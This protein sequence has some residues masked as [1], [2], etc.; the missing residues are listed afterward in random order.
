MKYS[1]AHDGSDPAHDGHTRGRFE[2]IAEAN[3]LA[4]A[5]GVDLSRFIGVIAVVNAN[6]D[7]SSDGQGNTALAVGQWF[8]QA[9]WK[10]S[11]VDLPTISCPCPGGGNHDHTGSGAYRVGFSSLGFPG[12]DKW[13]YCHICKALSY[14]GN[15]TVG[16]CAGGGTHDYTGSG[17][18]KLCGAND[19]FNT[20]FV[21]HETGHCLGLSH[22]WS[23][24]PDAEYGDPYDIMS[25]MR[26]ADFANKFPPGRE[27]GPGLNAPT[28]DKLGWLDESRVVSINAGAPAASLSLTAL[29]HPENSGTLMARVTSPNH[30]YT[31]EL[32]Q[33]SGWD[34]GIGQSV[35]LIHELR[36]CYTTGQKD[37]RWCRKCQ[38]LAWNGQ[39]QCPAGALHNYA[40]SMNYN[41]VGNT[42]SFAGQNNWKW[43]HKCSLLSY[44]AN[45]EGPGPC[46][47]GG[48]HDQTNSKNYT[49]LINNPSAPGQHGWRWC[50]KCQGLAY[51]KNSSLGT[52]AAGGLHEHSGSADYA[53]DSHPPGDSQW[54]WCNKC[55]GLAA[56]GYSSCV[57]D[58]LAH[59]LTQSSPYAV[60][61][62]DASFPGD[63][64]FRF[65]W[66]CTGLANSALGAK[67]CK[68]DWGI[69]DFS[70]SGVVRLLRTP[71]SP[72]SL[73]TGQSQWKWCR[74]CALVSFTGSGAAPCQAGGSHDYTG[75]PDYTLANFNDDTTFSSVEGSWPGR[76]TATR[77]GM[78]RF[79]LMRSTARLGRRQ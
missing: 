45:P 49:L 42:P 71:A 50:T 66:K 14:A 63:A 38:A 62:D 41:V 43:C 25:A 34:V 30:I 55:Q 21:G 61:L 6:V 20:T 18:Y 28:L 11:S 16:R 57:A 12:Q 77:R 13:K 64:D 51:G 32:R 48:V 9:T 27:A 75:S 74:K 56:D 40:G 10:Y 44:A 59:D 33:P 35:V 69:H 4:T 70:G 73:K 7:D 36:S 8:G 78:S 5:S 31:V 68:K 52:C 37:W 3:R 2:W 65:C 22:S 58:G 46:P 60:S 47:A 15:A 39:A 26:V 24:N 29:N 72:P 79:T 23:A 54:R 67:P 76:T 53:L 17:E 1:F 19:S